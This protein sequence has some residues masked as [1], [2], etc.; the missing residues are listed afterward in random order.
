M[1]DVM[2]IDVGNGSCKVAMSIDASKDPVSLLPPEMPMGMRA[3]AYA[4]PDG[5]IEVFPKIERPNRAIRDVKTHLGPEGGTVEL[6]EGEVTYSVDAAKVYAA[7]A[8]ELINL[9]NETLKNMGKKPV[10]RVVLTYPTSFINKKQVGIMKKSV[11]ELLVDGHKIEVVAMITESAAAA[12]D[13]VSYERIVRSDKVT[14]DKYSIV[15]GDIG[16]GTTDVAVMTST[17]DIKEPFDVVCQT[18][19]AEVG[20]RV[21]DEKVYDH[22]VRQLNEEGK[23]PSTRDMQEL[24]FKH[25]VDMKHSLSQDSKTVAYKDYLCDGDEDFS[26]LSLTKEDFES[27]I[28]PQVN[29]ILICVNEMMEHAK[30][31]NVKV[32][33]IILTGGSSQVPLIKQEIDKVYGA[34]GITVRV[35]RPSFAV[36]NGAARYAHSLEET[37]NKKG[38][39]KKEKKE[40]GIVQH[41]EHSYGIYRNNAENTVRL[42]IDSGDDLPAKSKTYEIYPK[43]DI[44]EIRVRRSRSRLCS[45]DDLPYSECEDVRRFVFNTIPNKAH[46]VGISIDAD[47]KLSVECRKPDGTVE[48][49]NTFEN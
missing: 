47:R 15:V 43:G 37:D 29:S 22:I 1:K 14:D 17:N 2:A 44:V 5:T 23:T 40:A 33:E 46:T 45:S 8:L 49:K 3:V 11:E 12:Y 32:N 24:R 26:A 9:G 7:L 13:T 31:K 10:Y 35:F 41:A 25:A 4:S 34:E 19:N 38:G 20:G 18:G 28:R 39:A 21:F 27:Y 48:T 30:E 6:T 42:L 16:H 36:V